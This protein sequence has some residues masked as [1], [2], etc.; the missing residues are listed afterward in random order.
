MDLRKTGMDLDFLTRVQR[1]TAV[2][3]ALAFMLIGVYY[4]LNFALGFLVGC[5]WGV[6]N[7]WALGRLLRAVIT[8]GD[9]NKRRAYI[10]AGVK[11]P[12]LYVG[13]YFILS[14][15]WFAPVSLLL[16]FSTLFLVIS[17]K[18]AGRAVLHLDDRPAA[19]ATMVVS[20]K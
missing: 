17:L 8:P 20:K 4:E 11:F 15:S 18:A 7:F 19:G 12:I 5:L 9:I 6:A 3:G 1:S 10:L 2:V 14:S 13:G 16:G